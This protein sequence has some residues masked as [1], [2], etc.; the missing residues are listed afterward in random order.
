MRNTVFIFMI[1]AVILGTSCNNNPPVPSVYDIEILETRELLLEE[2]DRNYVFGKEQVVEIDGSNVFIIIADYQKLS[3]YNLDNGKKIKE[4]LPYKERTISNFNYINEDSIF[5][6][7]DKKLDWQNFGQFQLI[8]YYG[9][10][11]E[12]YQYNIDTME[13]ENR[14]LDIKKILPPSQTGDNVLIVGGDAFFSTHSKNIGDVGTK[15]FM[16]NRFPF[17]M[18]Y[19]TLEQKFYLSKHN[20]FPYIEEG[21]YYPTSRQVQS[22]F[23]SGNNLPLIRYNYSSNVFEWDYKNDNI[24]VHSLK[25]KLIDTIPPMPIATSYHHDYL[26]FSYAQIYYDK[27]RDLY[28]ASVYFLG[29][30]YDDTGGLWSLILVNDK[31]EYLGEFYRNKNWPCFYTKDHI[32]DIYPKNDSVLN[33]DYLQIVKTKRDFTA[34]IDSCKEDLF[35][36]RQRKLDLTKGFDSNESYIVKFLKKQKDIQDKDY[37]IMTLYGHGGCPGCNV[38]VYDAILQNR[39]ELE[40]NPFYIIVTGNNKEE[41]CNDL[42]YYGLLDFKNLIIDSTGIIKTLTKH[43]GLRNPRLTIVKDDAV[44]LDS[45]YHAYDTEIALIPTMLTGVGNIQTVEKII[46]ID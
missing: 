18:R 42:D 10:I 41:A 44:V 12:K 23:I 33:V 46:I 1:I 8:D 27:Y 28:F 22:S 13:L 40:K 5:I 2:S 24:I 34:Y 14:N 35:M 43:D 19:N 17:F 37:R 21:I 36:R 31:F 26:E 29:N 45:I 3:F 39:E 7:Y 16:E 11:K 15:E 30:F 38:T 6:F 20:N 4:I 9:N 25:S 32:L